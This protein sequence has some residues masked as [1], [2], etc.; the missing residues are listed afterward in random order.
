MIEGNIPLD[1]SVTFQTTVGWRVLQPSCK[2]G[3]GAV[4]APSLVLTRG[5][6][7]GKGKGG[8]EP[9]LWQISPFYRCDPTLQSWGRWHKPRGEVGRP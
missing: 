4:G 9:F 7:K 2:P 5:P 8:L 3:P 1:I 6:G